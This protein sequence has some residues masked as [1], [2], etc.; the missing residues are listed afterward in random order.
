MSTRS[1]QCPNCGASLD[2]QEGQGLVVACPY[3]STSVIAPQEARDEAPAALSERSARIGE[4]GRLIR[5]GQKFQAVL[6]LREIFAGT[7]LQEAKQAV[8]HL[9]DGSA[10]RIGGMTLQIAAPPPDAESSKPPRSGSGLACVGLVIFAL[11]V[12]AA[13]VAGVLGTLRSSGVILSDR[14]SSSGPG[15]LFPTPTPT[16]ISFAGIA[17]VF[18]GEGVGPGLFTDAR[19]IGV[20]GAGNIYVAEHSE[21]RI[22]VFDPEGEF[23]TLWTVDNETPIVSLAVDRQGTVYLIH[24]SQ[25]FRHDG[26]TGQL[27][28]QVMYEDGHGFDDVAVAAD[29][30]LVTSWQRFEDDIVRFDARGNAILV[31]PAAISGQTGSAEL[32]TQVAVDGLGNIYALGTFTEAVF[33]FAP[34]GQFVNRFGG[35]GNEPGQFRAARA[36][37]VDGQGRVYVGDSKGVQVFDADGR[38]IDLI[39][40][41]GPVFGLAFSDQN[42]LFVVARHQ[43]IKYVIHEP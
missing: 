20:D 3:C 23:V 33:R 43:V 40:V 26:A 6:L 29:G 4:L 15:V 1:F 17:L 31:I 38:Y 41:D 30:G 39:E 28:G 14:D 37:A 8:E 5:A 12:T 36:I 27:L 10:V 2:V 22:Q 19:H 16:P 21:G 34:G 13:I 35:P 11:I 18:G 9:S 42:E 25:L 24:H 32:D 7:T